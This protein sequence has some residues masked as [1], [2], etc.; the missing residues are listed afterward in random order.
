MYQDVLTNKAV[1]AATDIISIMAKTQTKV[2]VAQGA[3]Q[4]V[5]EEQVANAGVIAPELEET[6][7]ETAE[8]DIFASIMAEDDNESRS[9]E[10]IVK[11]LL[12]SGKCRLLKGLTVKNV[13]ATQFDTH[14][15]LTFVVKEVII[16]DVR[17]KEEIDAFGEPVKR[18]GKTHNV[19][20]SSYA[21]S[22]VMKDTP[23]TAI[24]ATKVVDDPQFANLLFAG[25]RIDVLMQYVKAGEEYVNPFASNAEPTTFDRDKMIHHIVK[26]EMGEVGQDAYR[27]MLLK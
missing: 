9:R 19:Q 15:L 24:F 3:A 1:K 6:A 11:E 26:V 10:D 27:T 20:T 18:L 25:G 7:E 4:Q 14:A 8:D 23:K 12:A 2:A 16:G 17:D 13:V 22:G 5:A 21:V